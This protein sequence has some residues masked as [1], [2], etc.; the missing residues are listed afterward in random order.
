MKKKKDKDKKKKTK[1]VIE[2]EIMALIHAC[3]KKSVDAALD[4]ILG[5]WK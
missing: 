3:L 1:S 4:D 2:A 5:P